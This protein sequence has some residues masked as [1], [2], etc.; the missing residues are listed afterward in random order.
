MECEPDGRDQIRNA[1][2]RGENEGAQDDIGDVPAT[3]ERLRRGDHPVRPADN[4]G[5]RRDD[6]ERVDAGRGASELVAAGVLLLLGD[7]GAKHRG[8]SCAGSRM[9]RR[10]RH[11]RSE[12]DHRQREAGGSRKHAHGD[13]TTDDRDEHGHAA[14]QHEPVG[15]NAHRPGQQRREPEQ[16]GDVEDVRPDDDTHAGVLVAGDDRDDRRRDLRRIC[17]ERG[18]DPQ[19]RLREPEPLADPVELAREHDARCDRERERADEKQDRDGDRHGRR[20]VSTL[21]GRLR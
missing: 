3:R 7:R 5:E 10:H 1:R 15:V 14:R 4:R 13:E 2:E 20:S 9:Q 11:V 18:E 12:R 6:R 19:Q 21:C 16:A 8:E 17:A